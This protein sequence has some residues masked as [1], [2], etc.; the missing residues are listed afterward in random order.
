MTGPSREESGEAA[1]LVVAPHA[2]VDSVLAHARKLLVQ[3]KLGAKWQSLYSSVAERQ[4]CKLEVLG[5]VPS[6]AMPCH[7]RCEC[8][9]PGVSKVSC[10]TRPLFWYAPR[11]LPG[12]CAPRGA[13][14][15]WEF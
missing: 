1:R 13:R 10:V 15:S 6:R 5:S 4:F 14:A 3:A 9:P 12:S 8:S 2:A 11:A 7:A